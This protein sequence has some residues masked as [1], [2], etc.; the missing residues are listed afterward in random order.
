M[1]NID[2]PIDLIR[3]KRR[4]G[5]TQ[6]V[7]D[8]SAT[9]VAIADVWYGEREHSRKFYEQHGE[10]LGGFPGVWHFIASLA[11]AV[12]EAHDWSEREFIDYLDHLP[13]AAMDAMDSLEMGQPIEAE[14][15][16]SIA[17]E[18]ARRQGEP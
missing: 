15:F 5:V 3:V 17:I 8:H 11:R 9:A 16:L 13:G 6:R 10:R 2:L 18:A 7:N 4:A 1:K 14:D 12:D